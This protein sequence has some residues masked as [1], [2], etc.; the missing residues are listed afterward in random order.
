MAS[1][2]CSR[3]VYVPCSRPSRLRGWSARHLKQTT[4]LAPDKCFDMS[5]HRV[6]VLSESQRFS[7]HSAYWLAR[8]LQMETRKKLPSYELF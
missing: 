5:R 6:S 1:P 3:G 4:Q 2:E 7:L 8:E